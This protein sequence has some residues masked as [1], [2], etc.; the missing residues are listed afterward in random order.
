MQSPRELQQLIDS[1]VNAE[2]RITARQL[3]LDVD[4]D[5]CAARPEPDQRSK[6]RGDAV[7]CRTEAAVARSFTQSARH[8][9]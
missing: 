5:V 6:R 3:R 9:G 4:H 1:S 7:V 2:I 8:A